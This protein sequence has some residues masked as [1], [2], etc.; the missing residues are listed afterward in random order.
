MFIHMYIRVHGHTS[1]HV[2]VIP[3]ISK[4]STCQPAPAV[5]QR[6][7]YT[8]SVLQEATNWQLSDVCNHDM[9]D[10][11]RGHLEVLKHLAFRQGKRITAMIISH[12]A[13][14]LNHACT[15]PGQRSGTPNCCDNLILQL[16]IVLAKPQRAEYFPVSRG[17]ATKDIIHFT[18]E[19]KLVYYDGNFDAFR[20][21]SISCQQRLSGPAL[22]QFPETGKRQSW[23]LRE[24]KVQVPKNYPAVALNAFTC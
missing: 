13:G 10:R 11:D 2:H 22:L 24:P 23:M 21:C 1:V 8:R 12:D 19:G 5:E 17:S 20:P 15:E 14:F 4:H 3:Y 16:Q 7:P 6:R 9:C 18:K